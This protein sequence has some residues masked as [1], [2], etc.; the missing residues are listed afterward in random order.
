MKVDIDLR[1]FLF[2]QFVSVKRKF[3]TKRQYATETRPC[4][5]DTQIVKCIEW[6][7][8]AHDPFG[9]TH[10]GIRLLRL[11]YDWNGKFLW[12]PNHIH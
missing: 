10:S 7:L 1:W 2:K 12:F 6:R 5:N 9:P 11:T 8:F 3:I 4:H